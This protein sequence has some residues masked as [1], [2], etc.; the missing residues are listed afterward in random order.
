[1][2]FLSIVGHAADVNFFPPAP[3]AKSVDD[4]DATGFTIDGK[5]TFLASGS[6]HYARAPRALWHDRLLRLKRAGF[7]TVQTYVF[8]NYHE[9]AEN[10]FDFTV[11]RTSMSSSRP[12]RT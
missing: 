6:F 3:E 9:P 7:N 10:S 8:C 4:F 2:P 5:R 11:K 1:M 12:R